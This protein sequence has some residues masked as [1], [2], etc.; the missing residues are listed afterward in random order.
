VTDIAYENGVTTTNTYNNARS[1]MMGMET[2]KLGTVLQSFVYTRDNAGRIGTMVVGPSTTE[3][4][5]YSH[6][7]CDRHLS[8]RRGSWLCWQS[9]LN[10]SL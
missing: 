7:G 9:P 6:D 5:T 2:E 3:N 10:P 4:W 8:L 1:W